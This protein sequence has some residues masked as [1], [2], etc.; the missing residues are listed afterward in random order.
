MNIADNTKSKSL[1]SVMNNWGITQ[2]I[3]L[4]TKSIGYNKDKNVY[5]IPLYM[6][7]FL[8]NNLTCDAFFTA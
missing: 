3:R 6:A 1:D 8:N 2:G 5:I 4:S 7:M